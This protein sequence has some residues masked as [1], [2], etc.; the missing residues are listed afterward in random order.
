LSNSLPCGTVIDME[1]GECCLLNCPDKVIGSVANRKDRA[2]LVAGC[3]H[4]KGRAL[5]PVKEGILVD[6]WG[7]D[8]EC[9][10]VYDDQKKADAMADKLRKK[11]PN[12]DVRFVNAWSADGG[13]TWKPVEGGS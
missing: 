4:W 11:C 7:C 6:C 10:G 5:L 3:K 9:G 2:W 1:K 13:N 8:G 12:A